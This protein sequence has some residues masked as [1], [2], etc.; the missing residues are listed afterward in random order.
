MR[1]ILLVVAVALVVGVG[2]LLFFAQGP[3]QRILSPEGSTV[4]EFSGD[5]DEIT[6]EFQVREG[7]TIHWENSGVRFAFAIT[8]DRDFGTVIEQDEPASG[9]TSPVGEGTFRLEIEAEGPWEIRIVQG[10]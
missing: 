4:A 9:V 3:G 1:P 2:G 10:E 5:G 8:G 6:D 7:W